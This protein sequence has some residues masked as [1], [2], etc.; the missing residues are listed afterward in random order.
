VHPPGEQPRTKFETSQSVGAPGVTVVCGSAAAE[1]VER[2]VR[3]EAV[4]VVV[5]CIREVGL[6]FGKFF[7]VATSEMLNFRC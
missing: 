5:S 2:R 6:M 3:R 7:E 4:K 1:V